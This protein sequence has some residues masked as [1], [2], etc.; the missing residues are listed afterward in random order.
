LAGAEWADS[1]TIDAHK[2]LNVP[3]DAAMTFTRY[4]TMQTAVFQNAA[5]YLGEMGEHPAPVH[6]TPQNSRRFRGLATWMTLM[7]YGRAGYQEIVERNCDQASWLA[8][9]IEQSD[10]FCLLAPVQMNVVCFTLAG[11]PTLARV[12]DYLTRLQADGRVFLTPTNY[13]GTPG[14]RAAISN[15]QTTQRDLEIAWAAMQETEQLLR[16]S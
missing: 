16:S 13:K 4:P 3:Y 7:A 10:K 14:L 8:E 5:A 2:W 11:E 9:Q 6:W 1:I 12:N 15:W